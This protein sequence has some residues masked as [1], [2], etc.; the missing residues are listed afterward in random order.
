MSLVSDIL[1][2]SWPCWTGCIVIVYIIKDKT[3]WLATMLYDYFSW[4]R[5]AGDG[6]VLVLG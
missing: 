1:L 6:W 3:T 2:A 4:C 5:P